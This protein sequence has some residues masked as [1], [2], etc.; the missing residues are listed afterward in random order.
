MTLSTRPLL[1][2]ADL[3][4]IVAGLAALILAP[5]APAATFTPREKRQLEL[6]NN[7]TTKPTLKWVALRQIARAVPAATVGTGNA[8]RSGTAPLG[9]VGRWSR[10]AIWRALGRA[11]GARGA[12]ARP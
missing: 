12:R 6:P 10:G 9:R 3:L 8:E 7:P 2:L 1:D 5:T 4:W 11:F